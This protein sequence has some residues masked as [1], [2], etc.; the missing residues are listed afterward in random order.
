ML[1]NFCDMIDFKLFLFSFCIGI[2]F[3]YTLGADRKTVYMY[4]SPNTY[5]D[6]VIQDDAGNCYKYEQKKV[7]CEKNKD[8]IT[9]FPVQSESTEKES[10]EDKPQNKILGIF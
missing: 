1:S 9:N 2:L 8:K 6:I 7:P 4:P 3:V 5:K 10:E